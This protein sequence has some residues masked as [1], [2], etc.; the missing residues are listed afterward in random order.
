MSNENNVHERLAMAAEHLADARLTDADGVASDRAEGNAIDESAGRGS[1]GFRGRRRR[2]HAAQFR[3]LAQSILLEEAGVPHFLRLAMFGVTGLVIATIAWAAVTHVDEVATGL[4]QVSPKGRV[5]VV[6]HLADG[7]VADILVH[8]GDLVARGDIL[9]RLDATAAMA[10]LEQARAREGDLQIRAARLEAFA[11]GKALELPPAFN[12]GKYRR[13]IADQRAILGQ[14]R[15]AQRSQREVLQEQIRGRPSEIMV[16][17]TRERSL[18]KQLKI[19]QETFVMRQK[20]LRRGV[21]S[22]VQYLEIK[23]NLERTRGALDTVR[24]RMR[25]A[26]DELAEFKGR[27]IALNARLRREALAERGKGTAALDERGE[28]L[29]GCE[30]R[31]KRLTIRAPTRGYVKGLKVNTIGGVIAGGKPLLEIV[32]IDQELI[33]E[34]RISTRD[35]GYVRVGQRVKVKVDTYDFARYGAVGGRLTA[36]SASTFLDRRGRPYYKGTVALDHS[37][38]GRDPRANPVLAGMTVKAEIVTGSKSILAYLTKPVRTKRLLSVIAE[39]IGNYSPNLS[40]KVN[41]NSRLAIDSSIVD[42]SI[43]E[44]FASMQSDPDFLPGLLNQFQD[45][46]LRLIDDIETALE[47][48][49]YRRFKEAVHSLKG[50]A[51]SVGAISLQ[52]CCIVI[53]KIDSASLLENYDQVLVSINKEYRRAHDALDS[54]AKM[55]DVQAK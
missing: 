14:Q 50:N 9:I 22:R 31:V 13:L 38:V 39:E 23:G 33:V 44:E 49:D 52:Q 20:L 51:G 15:R 7:I 27:L 35:I 28:K 37:Y 34:T 42:V 54:Y 47:K 25:K 29:T 26:K 43:L 3:F 53:E 12:V 5:Q 32:P 6:Q 45:D 46:A 17:E 19:V 55:R 21:A 41:G 48:G 36:I 1:G 10:E 16:L 18:R 2:A 30:G 24:A 40:S 11:G 4:G 8:D